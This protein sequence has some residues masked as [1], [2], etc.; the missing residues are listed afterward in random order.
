MNE[1]R[2]W[3][4]ASVILGDARAE[5]QSFAQSHVMEEPMRSAGPHRREDVARGKRRAGQVIWCVP[6]SKIAAK[7]H[8]KNCFALVRN[9][10]G[11]FAKVIAR[12][13]VRIAAA[14]RIAP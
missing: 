14:A 7:K 8:Q 10:I 5:A 9:E 12:G 3:I 6:I 1:I 11:G 2:G 13:V 4:E